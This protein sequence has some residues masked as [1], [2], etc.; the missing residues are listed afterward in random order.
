MWG[1]TRAEMHE[2]LQLP[3]RFRHYRDGQHNALNKQNLCNHASGPVK[4]QP[5]DLLF[6]TL[7]FSPW[8]VIDQKQRA[9]HARGEA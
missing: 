2:A 9:E 1:S 4:Q 3:S 5:S 8:I 7:Y 6:H